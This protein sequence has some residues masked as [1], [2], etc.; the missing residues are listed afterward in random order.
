[1]TPSLCAAGKNYEAEVG[2]GIF[3]NSSDEEEQE[4]RIMSGR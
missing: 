2:N 4:K 1:M 3:W